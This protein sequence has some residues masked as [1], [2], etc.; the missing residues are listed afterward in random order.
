M[1]VLVNIIVH[2]LLNLSR[3]RAW[4]LEKAALPYGL[5]GGWLFTLKY[6]NF[7]L[8]DAYQKFR[9]DNFSRVLTIFFHIQKKN[10]CMRLLNSCNILVRGDKTAQHQACFRFE[11]RI[12]AELHGSLHSYTPL[13]LTTATRLVSET[14]WMDDFTSYLCE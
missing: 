3:I 2:S 11:L 8:Y 12:K 6:C 7:P 13:L 5:W 10:P 1:T 9:S 14:T 4:L